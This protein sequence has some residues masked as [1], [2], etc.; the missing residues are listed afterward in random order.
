MLIVFR[1]DASNEIGSGHVMRCLTLAK[2]LRNKGAECR[3]VSREHQGN[4]IGLIHEQGFDVV[5]LPARNAGEAIS[6]GLYETKHAG[7]LGDSWSNDAALTAA[8]LGTSRPDWLIVDHYAL[9]INWENILRPSCRHLMVIDD[10]AD[11][12]HNCDILLDQNLVSNARTR[13]KDKVP[14]ACEL[15]LGPEFALLQPQYRELHGSAMRRN[16][17]VRRI[18][19]YFGAGNFGSLIVL[20][21]DAFLLLDLGDVELDV[22]LSTEHPDAEMVCNRIGGHSNITLHG[23]LPSLAPLMM[24]A[25]AAVGAGGATSWERCCLGLATL[26]ITIADNQKAAAAELHRQGMIRWLGDKGEVT[27]SSLHQELEAL[28]Q[29]GVT[30]EMAAKCHSLVDGD[31]AGRVIR[32]LMERIPGDRHV[33]ARDG[34]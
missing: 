30:N 23:R 32:K 21:I 3:F 2:A 33:L 25:D 17:P 29:N 6:A 9:D 4:M 34:R 16:D 14:G 18:L 22:V 31:G 15:L 8:A 11:R 5:C 27:L 13:Y 7:W 28:L 1:V 10:L 20:T 19:V 24:N 12:L 26:V